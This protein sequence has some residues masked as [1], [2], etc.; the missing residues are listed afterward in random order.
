[1]KNKCKLFIIGVLVITFSILGIVPQKVAAADENV[2]ITLHKLLF[3]NGQVPDQ[4]QNDGLT[5]PF[6]SDNYEGVNNVTFT[7]YDV[8]DAFYKLRATGL[9]VEQAQKK[10]AIDVSSGRPIKTNATATEN[11]VAAIA[12]FSLPVKNDAGKYAVYRFVETAHPDNITESA[13][14]LVVVL[15]VFD[16]DDQQ[17]SSID[18]YPKNEQT[19]YTPPTVT[20]KITAAQKSFGNGAEIPF[21][22]TTTIPV[23]IW[24]YQNFVVSDNAESALTLSA[25]PA[26]KING[27]KV[28]AAILSQTKTAHGFTIHFDPQVLNDYLGQTI[29]ISYA[30]HFAGS[31]EQSSYQNAVTVTP[32]T[33]PQITHEAI[34]KTGGKT[35]I[36]VDATNQQKNLSDAEFVVKNADGKYL[37]RTA[38]GD[39][40]VASAKATADKD[41]FRLIS[42]RDGTFSINDLAYGDYELLEVKAPSTYVLSKTTIHFK[43]SATSF[44]KETALKVVNKK[45]PRPGIPITGLMT[46]LPQTGEQVVRSLPYLGI[47]IIAGALGIWFY[48]KNKKDSSHKQEENKNENKDKK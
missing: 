9:S 25:T 11:N 19:H 46:H 45:R 39:Q 21:E 24:E 8:S 13:T 18:L 40:W 27:K 48:K 34:V 42:A 12:R 28:A 4:I 1:M 10:L 33:H 37:V 17:L 31:A 2:T 30:M 26:V 29:S 32:G 20:K 14:P 15:P 44:K 35:F 36:K 23:D 6:L 7:A 5:N 22:I 43:V 41:L 3:E 16:A 47:V 38:D